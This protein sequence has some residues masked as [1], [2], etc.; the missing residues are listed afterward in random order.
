VPVHKL[1]TCS[2]PGLND[3]ADLRHNLVSRFI[4]EA[5]PIAGRATVFREAIRG[6]LR[7]VAHNRM[8]RR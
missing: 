6:R 2:S 8:A 4:I 5:T 7:P 3:F 1:A